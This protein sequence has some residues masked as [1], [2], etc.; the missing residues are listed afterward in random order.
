MAN[1]YEV[2]QLL[3]SPKGNR[4]IQIG[5]LIE[6][7]DDIAK[8][9]LRKDCI[10]PHFVRVDLPVKKTKPRRRNKYVTNN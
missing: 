3:W 8:I 10:K 9:L 7:E 1:V 6:L 5:E 2:T 4:Y